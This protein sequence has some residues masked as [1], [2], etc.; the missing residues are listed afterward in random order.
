MTLLNTEYCTK[1]IIYKLFSPPAK[2]PQ[3]NQK[4]PPVAVKDFIFPQQAP[5][6]PSRLFVAA[7]VRLHSLETF[8]H[9]PKFYRD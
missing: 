9:F 2:A 6:P 8:L 5:L 3:Q 7:L 4:C 1:Y